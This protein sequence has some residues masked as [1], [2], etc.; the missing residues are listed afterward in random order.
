MTT[1]TLFRNSED[2]LAFEA[3]Q[4]IFEKG[5]PGDVMYAVLEG[6]VEIVL[7]GKVIDSAGPGGIIGEMALIDSSPRSA[8]A[9]AKTACR[10]V[11]VGEK[12]FTFLVQ[13]T[14]FFSLQVMRIMA[15]R[16]RRLMAAQ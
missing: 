6:E 14:P 5:Q 12:R 7:D 9:R 16:L 2:A 15:E 3:S 13:Q 10:L 11:P 1:I 4:V 8:T